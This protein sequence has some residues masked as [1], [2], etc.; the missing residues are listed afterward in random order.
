MLWCRYLND[1][2]VTPVRVGFAV[3]RSYGRAVERNRLR[4]RLRAI[5]AE[6]GLQD[7]ERARFPALPPAG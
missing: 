7:L 3:G 5:L 2:A 1:P 6:F 4:R